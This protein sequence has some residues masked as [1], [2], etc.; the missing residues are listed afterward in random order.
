METALEAPEGF[1]MGAGVEGDDELPHATVDARANAANTNRTFILISLMPPL[2]ANP[3]PVWQ[4]GRS[5]LSLREST[6]SAN[7]RDYEILE[8][9][10]PRVTAALPRGRRGTLLNVVTKARRLWAA[11]RRNGSVRGALITEA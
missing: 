5:P 2:H 7:T 8:P 1:G 4:S 3:L 10:S 9:V 6:I 11:S